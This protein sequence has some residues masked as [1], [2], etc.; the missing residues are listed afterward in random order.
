LRT[1]SCCADCFGDGQYLCA[2]G[3]RGAAHAPAT[4][5]LATIKAGSGDSPYP[6]RRTVSDHDDLAI[7][8]HNPDRGRHA[9]AVTLPRA[10]W[11]TDVGLI[12]I[13]PPSR[14]LG[15]SCRAVHSPERG[16]YG[17]KAN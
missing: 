2:Y 10:L 15:D 17:V 1:K 9:G 12:G 5:H 13:R 7:V 16:I 14:P 6:V 3:H 4:L 11:L 8:G